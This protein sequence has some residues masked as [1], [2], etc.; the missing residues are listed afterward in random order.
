MDFARS[1]KER[2]NREPRVEE[3]YE[4]FSLFVDGENEDRYP[5]LPVS[6][7]LGEKGYSIWK[8]S[9]KRKYK[10]FDEFIKNAL[11]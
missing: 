9:H 10:D 4:E 7:Q 2:F 6:S 11:N 3:F 1:I 5:S 8:Q